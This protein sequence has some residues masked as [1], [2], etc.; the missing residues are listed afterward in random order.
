MAHTSDSLHALL[1]ELR[2]DAA[3][4]SSRGP[5]VLVAGPTDAGKSSLCRHLLWHSQLQVYDEDT[6][7]PT[8]S[9]SSS[10]QHQHP[11]VFADLDIG[12]GEIGLPGTI[13]ASVVTRDNFVVP[14]PADDQVDLAEYGSEH[15]FPLTWLRNLLFYVGHTNMSEKDWL[16]KWYVQQLATRIRDK[17]AADPR[18]AA[19]GAVINTCGWVEGKGLR[20]L[21]ATIAIFQPSHVVVL[22]DVNLYNHL[23]HEQVTPVVLGLPR[24]YL[25]QRR[26]ASS[27]RDTRNGRLRTYFTPPP[28]GSGSPESFHIEVATSQVRLF[29]LVQSQNLV[30]VKRV[31]LTESVNHAVVAM[32]VVESDH[33]LVRST[34]LGFLCIRAVNKDSVVFV[35]PRPGPLP[36]NHFLLGQVQWLEA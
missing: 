20:L 6:S 7:S 2:V 9:S 29:T 13:G 3:R 23:L 35:S 18:L 30:R 33:M 24:S 16:F 32:C 11:I 10:Q 1:A 8:T 12:Q 14:A 36:S 34:V 15:N 22:G 19:S 5:M 17:Q 27:R 31:P 26:S 28:R 25:A 4:S 21:L